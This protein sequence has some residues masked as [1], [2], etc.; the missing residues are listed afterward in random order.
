[1]SLTEAQDLADRCGLSLVGVGGGSIYKLV[2]AGKRKYL[3]KKA[4]AR[5]R[6][7]CHVVKKRVEI[8]S[9]I[10]RNDLE[11]KL[12]A[13]QKF[14]ARSFRVSVVAKFL[15]SATTPAAYDGFVAN[16]KL[17]LSLLSSSALEPVFTELG[18]CVFYLRRSQSVQRA[19]ASV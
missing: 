13:I 12:K 7:A 17:R 18:D 15:R 4:A 8:K 3:E 2:D 10:G 1:M 9:N 16:L 5:Q 6:L 14:L 11:I 19:Q